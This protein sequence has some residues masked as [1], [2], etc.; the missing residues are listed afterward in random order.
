M[1]I[2]NPFLGVILPIFP[3]F[4]IKVQNSTKNAYMSFLLNRISARVSLGKNENNQQ[5]QIFC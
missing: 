1:A 3:F 5:K 2:K 4:L